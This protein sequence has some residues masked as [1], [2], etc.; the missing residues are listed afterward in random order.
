M[1]SNEVAVIIPI[2]KQNLS[3]HEEFCLKRNITVLKNY[4]IITVAPEKLKPK[5]DKKLEIDDIE[6]FND[7]YFKDIKG[8]NKLMLSK[9]F[10]SRFINYKYVLICQLDVFIFRDSLNE[11]CKMDYDYIGAPWINKP[12]FLFQYVLLKAGVLSALQMLFTR[13]IYNTV[14]NG[15]LSLR[16]VST[17]LNSINQSKQS[18]IWK[19][20]EDIYW[21]FFAKTNGRILKKPSAREAAKFCIE[22]SPEKIMKKQ[23]FNLPMGIHAWDKYNPEFWE[24]YIKDALKECGN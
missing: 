8:Y 9:E 4:P 20:N 1:K 10:Y 24:Q 12:F 14:G 23:N 6:Y 13:N 18:Q 2:Y 7:D 21:S 17:F 11:W 15:G 19:A 3:Q 5:S 16:K 22:L